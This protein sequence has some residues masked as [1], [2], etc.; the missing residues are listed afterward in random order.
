MIF[1]GLGDAAQFL[2]KVDAFGAGLRCAE[3][4]VWLGVLIL[5]VYRIPSQK[6]TWH[7]KITPWKR[8]CPVETTIFSG[9]MLV[10]GECRFS[11]IFYVITSSMVADVYKLLDRCVWNTLRA[12][13]EF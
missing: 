9:Y 10:L 2:G 12:F 7:L 6:L 13:K 1:Q 4:V 8:R 11:D 5:R 3:S